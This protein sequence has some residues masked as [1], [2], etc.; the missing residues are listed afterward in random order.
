MKK[1]DFASEDLTEKMPNKYAAVIVI[2]NRAK[3]IRENPGEVDEKERK[4]KP[5]V[6]AI[7]E[8][9]EGKLKFSDFDI[10]IINEERDK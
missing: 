9:K 1:I 10:E 4:V 2:S 8:F 6:T 5:P 3:E 7:K